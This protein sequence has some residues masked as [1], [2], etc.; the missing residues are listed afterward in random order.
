M[1]DPLRL[2]CM[3]AH[4]HYNVVKGTVFDR[5]CCQHCGVKLGIAPSGQAVIAAYP[6]V[7]IVC[8]GCAERLYGTELAQLAPGAA[9]EAIETLTNDKGTTH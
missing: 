8:A 7:E 3:P 9:E 4:L 6:D 5:W 2:I 1:S